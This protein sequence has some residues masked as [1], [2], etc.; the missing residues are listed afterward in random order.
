MKKPASRGD[1][2]FSNAFR[3]VSVETVPSEP[4]HLQAQKL[5]DRYGLSSAV[6]AVVASLAY[7]VPESWRAQA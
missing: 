2:G 1:T 6:A 5:A 4:H 3:Q 7:G